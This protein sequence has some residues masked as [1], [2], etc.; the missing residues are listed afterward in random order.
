MPHRIHVFLLRVI[1]LIAAFFT[2]S[3][4]VSA[5]TYPVIINPG[6]GTNATDGLRIE[7]NQDGSY[8]VFRKGKTE[9]ARDLNSGYLGVRTHINF[10]VENPSRPPQI[11]TFTNVNYHAVSPLMGSGTAADP[12]QVSMIAKVFNN[13]GFINDA[14]E[15]LPAFQDTARFQSTVIMTITYVKPN[16]YYTIDYTVYNQNFDNVPHIFVDEFATLQDDNYDLPKGS[17][18]IIQYGYR[19]G[20]TA[21]PSVIGLRRSTDVFGTDATPGPLIHVYHA[22]NTF[23]SYSVGN[24]NS[25]LVRS[26]STGRL[27]NA[28]PTFDLDDGVRKGMAVDISLGTKDDDSRAIGTR[29]AVSYGDSLDA[30]IIPVN[31]TPTS[32]DSKPITVA[33]ERGDTV[34][35]EG[36]AGDIH[37]PYNLRLK[38][39]SGGSVKYPI[40]VKVNL[41]P[42]TP[43]DANAAVLGTD[44]NFQGGYMIPVG[45]YPTGS[46]IP[47]KNISIIGNN[48]LEY[49]RHFTIQLEQVVDNQMLLIGGGPTTCLYTIK[50]DEPKNIVLTTPAKIK[51]GFIDTVRVALPAGVHASERTQVTLSL[52]SGTEATSGTDF[53]FDQISYIEVDS[54]GVNIPVRAKLD[55]IIEKDELIKFKADAAVM[56]EP[57]T[58][59]QSMLLQD[60][61]R[62]NPA[63]TV[64]S[65][66]ADAPALLKELYDG[67]LTFSLPLHVTTDLPIGIKINKLGTSTAANIADY[68]L[69]DTA[70]IPVGGYD[71][72]V[73]FKLINDNKIEGTERLDLSL[74]L[75]ESTANTILTNTAAALDIIDAQLPMTAPVVLHISA[76]SVNEGVDPTVWAE[77]PAGLSTQI[78]I[79]VKFTR[80]GSSTALPNTYTFATDSVTIPAGRTLSDT[81]AITNTSNNVFDDTRDLVLVGSSPDNGILVKDS[82]KVTIV[83]NTD[84]SKKV[85]TLT[86]DSLVLGEGNSTAFKMSLPVGYRSAKPV[87]IT[88]TTNAAGTEAA[89]T[90]YQYLQTS[91]VFP[92]DTAVFTT[93]AAVIKA[94]T[95]QIIEKDEQ[96]NITGAAAGYTVVDAQLK[97]NDSTRRK[98]AN[99]IVTFTPPAAGM[100][101][102]NTQQIGFKLPT[103]ITT[104]IPIKISLPS[105]GTA[106]RGADYSL[107]ADTTFTGNAGIA[108]VK[109]AG[110][111]LVEDTEDIHLTPSVSDL[112][113]TAYTFTPATFD[114]TIKDA[115]YPFPAGT[116]VKLSSVPDT[117]SEGGSAVI[118][119]TFPNGWKAG[120][121]WAIN[122]TKDVVSSTIANSRYDSI[123]QIITIPVGADHGTAI[124]IQTVTNKVF[125]DEGNIVVDGNKG[126]TNMPATSVSIHVK[127]A[128]DPA[129]K[130]LTLTADSLTL[131]EGNSTA[132]KMSLPAGYHSAKP[133][134]IAL[135]TNATGTEAATTDYQYLQTSIVFPKDTAVFT[136]TA[137]VIGAVPDQIIEKDEQLNISGTANGYTVTGAQLNIW[138]ATRRDATKTAI[139]FTP[140]T[141]GMPEGSTQQIGF[142]L[143]T[144][145]STEIPIKISLP[146]TGAASRSADYSL[147]TDTTFTGTAGAAILKVASDILVEDVEDI[148]V[149]PVISDLYSTVYTFTPPTLDLTIKDAQYPFP[150]G[151]FVKLTSVPDSVNEGQSAAITAT[152]PNGWKAGKAWT[153]NL[154]KDAVL[155]T[156]ADSRHGAIPATI[157][158]ANNASSGTSSFITTNTNSILDD[159]GAIIVTGNKGDVNMPADSAAIY[160]KDLTQTQPGARKITLTPDA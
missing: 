139:T 160:I 67:Q 119:A 30:I 149:S 102:G 99:I 105:T 10:N 35:V 20:S 75:T 137:A 77:L 64:V 154:A 103:G 14:D 58:F 138:D 121:A 156:V 6:G 117:V 47:L 141:A 127:D 48:K 120:K 95:D 73:A 29:L 91:I 57:Q 134:T 27:N 46:F 135:T 4:G 34:G 109:V 150:A 106:G 104:E 72:P 32:T 125:D 78:P 85:L 159:E 56:G 55:S 108:E 130:K 89:T 101:E 54:N 122:L 5:Q 63:L 79:K 94:I 40:Y 111:N 8:A 133:V 112:Y 76:A 148:H 52:E 3:I 132:F 61:T 146:S 124:A 84:P 43:G 18:N 116:S 157:T 82:V 37:A 145:V 59:S 15:S 11:G 31:A 17:N 147:P 45:E 7:I 13:E 115:Q 107:P 100:P 60:S 86:A 44:F 70:T 80:G 97:I 28:F 66:N 87:T 83:D 1:C 51:E 49:A 144:G 93:T 36:N 38:V 62:L 23:N 16:K 136:T 155:S 22:Y 19:L 24:Y 113:S 33:F 98:P 158:I 131:R 71:I 96:L 42:A 142:K 2:I 88:L 123:Q 69:P 65:I 26:S 90:D 50:D 153:I 25:R 114:L 92:K 41:L 151:T 110:D 53:T 118:T 9:T 68:Q 74:T 12:Y 129:Q 143:P 39:T 126:N 140:P 21:N 152:F 128:T 81:L